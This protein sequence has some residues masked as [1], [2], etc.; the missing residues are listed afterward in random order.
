MYPEAEI[1]SIETLL[2]IPVTTT[3]PDVPKR[4]I[5]LRNVVTIER[6][7]APTEVVHY[8][9][10]PTI[11]LTLGVHGRDLGHVSDDVDRVLDRFGRPDPKK[12]GEWWPYDPD[13]SDRRVLPG[14]KIVLS[15]EYLRMKDTFNNLAVCLG[16]AALLIYFLMVGLDQSFLVPLAVMSIVPLGLVGI[17]TVLDPTRSAGDCPAPLRF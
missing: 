17:M 2:D 9:I 16:L 11:E 12:S 10:Q 14:S 3:R 15:G 8:N 5:P 1:Q 4:P 6:N 7:T 13:G